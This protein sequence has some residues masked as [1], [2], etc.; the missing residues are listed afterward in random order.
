MGGLGL[1]NLKE[2]NLALLTKWGWRFKTEKDNL[3]VKV[4]GAI[5]SGGSA[6]D[7]LP[8]RKSL[9]GGVWRNIVS[10]LNKPIVD[11]TPIRNFFRGIV[12][13]GE[14]I[15][16]WLDPWLFDIPLKDKYPDLF[17]LEM[18]KNCS[19][20]D[21]ISGDGLWLWKHDVDTDSEKK[22]WA[23]LSSALGSVACSS[24]PDRWAWVGAGSESFSVAAVKKLIDGSK[25]FSSRYVMEWCSWVPIKCNIFMW[26]AELDRIPTVEALSRR[27]VSVEDH[28]CSFCDDGLDSVSHMFT[29]CPFALQLWE[30]ISLWCRL[31]R[32]IIFS[33]RDLVEVHNHGSRLES[34]KKAIQGV[35]FTACWLLWKVRN[36]VRFSNKRRSVEDLFCEVRSVSF[37][38]FKYRR[39]KG[40][41]DW[42]DWF[43]FVNM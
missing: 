18:V 3:W 35:I 38:W 9:G 4:V 33:F 6:W 25:D 11:N 26:R 1:H 37:V 21:R 5:H 19:V 12:G 10:L 13:S 29:A 24:R 42:N 17:R 40:L 30:K 34:E 22:D 36:D 39:K 2:V 7:F 41:L 23:D 8:I 15:L 16:F 28:G 31:N 14:N 27:G 43:R 32:F 20:S